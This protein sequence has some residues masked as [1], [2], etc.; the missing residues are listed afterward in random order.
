MHSSIEYI[1]VS[2]N[3]VNPRKT[4]SSQQLWLEKLSSRCLIVLNVAKLWLIIFKSYAG[5]FSSNSIQYKVR[6]T[7]NLT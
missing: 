5:L 1:S 4:V 2:Y 3:H 6:F 7:V